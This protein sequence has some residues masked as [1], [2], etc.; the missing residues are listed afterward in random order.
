MKPDLYLRVPLTVIAVC[1]ALLLFEEIVA[2]SE[3][4]AEIT[5]SIGMKLVLI[6]PGE[7]MMGSPASEKDKDLDENPQRRVRI[8]KPFYIGKY[9]VTQLQYGIVMGKN[10]SHF[11][12][13]SNPVEKVSWDDAVEF[14]KRLSEKEGVTYRLPTEAEWEYACRAGTTTAFCHGVSLSSGQANF[15]GRYPCGGAKNGPYR[16]K[17]TPVGTFTP[18]AWGLHD[19]HGNLWEWCADW[20]QRDYYSH[21][22][23]DDPKGPT[24]GKERVLRGGSWQYRGWVCRSGNRSKWKPTGRYPNFGFRVA[25]SGWN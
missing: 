7:F 19:M 22:T 10:P 17:T 23:V 16:K 14:C 13:V 8:T 12:G 11:K 9:E 6:P 20:Y 18:N 4:P 24:S 5:N 2:A 1:S 3:L 25:R 21:S 15:D